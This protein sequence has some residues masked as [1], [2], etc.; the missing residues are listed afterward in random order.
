L[1]KLF[2]L[3]SWAPAGQL[4]ASLIPYPICS[5]ARVELMFH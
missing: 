5:E 1:A 2:I 4:P 3:K